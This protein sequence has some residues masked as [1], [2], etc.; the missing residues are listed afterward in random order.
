MLTLGRDGSAPVKRVGLPDKGTEALF[1]THD[2]NLRFLEDA[3]KVRIKSHGQELV[4]E[5]DEKGVETA[6]SV[7]EQLAGLMKEGYSV[8]AADV[9]LAA[10]L[11]TQDP[12]VRLREYLLKNVA[13]GTKKVV[14]PRSLNQRHYLEKI[15][16]NDM[17]FGIGPAGTGKTYLAVAQGVAS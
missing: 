5:G 10:Q 11:L 7:L 14:I 15:E 13:R 2:E 3:L 17:V 6:T 8:A 9:R 12:T 4:L 16:Q 1:G